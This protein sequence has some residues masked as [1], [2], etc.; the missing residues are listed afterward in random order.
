MLS[1]I[2]PAHNEQDWIGATLEGLLTQDASA[3]EFGGIEVIVAANGCADDTAGAARA[4]EAAFARKG[5]ALVV[6]DIPRGGKTNAMNEADRIA[7]GGP[8]IYMD[9]DV[10]CSPPLIGQL[11]RAASVE[12]P[13]YCSGW[14]VPSPSRSWVTRC[15]GRVWLKVPYMKTN[16]PGTGICAVSPAGRARWGD[17]P[18]ITSDDGFIRLNFAPQERVAVPATF[19]TPLAE[20][21]SRLVK[22]RR[23]QDRGGAE[24]A[25][26]F[27][28]LIANESKPPMRLS[29]Y[30]G[31][32]LG[33]PVCFI[34]YVI[35][36]L[37]VRYG[38]DREGGT[39]SRG[40]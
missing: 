13:R 37:A 9:A 11:G 34:V 29:D 8:R 25:R 35:I 24:L 16:V 22:V 7:R 2:I 21:F 15:F 14:L 40:R 6:L 4:Y 27:P 17:L 36:I 10:I 1:I 26:A 23:R 5:W 28:A 20:G 3:G 19:V 33:Q 31:L 30:L 12:E 18:E 32:F 38:P 39:W